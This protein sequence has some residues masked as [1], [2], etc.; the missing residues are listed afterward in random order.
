MG[1]IC[2]TS[3]MPAEAHVGS[4]LGAQGGGVF[5]ADSLAGI[6][7]DTEIPMHKQ[8][9]YDKRQVFWETRIEGRQ[10]AWQTI[11]MAAECGDPTTAKMI[12]SS[13]GLTDYQ[14]DKS[15]RRSVTD[16]CYC[17]DELGNRYDVPLYVLFSPRTL[18]DDPEEQAELAGE[19]PVKQKE[20]EEQQKQGESKLSGGV[21]GST[22]DK[23]EIKVKVRLSSSKDLALS[24]P[25][26][27]NVLQLKTAVQQQEDIAVSRLRV[28]VHGHRLS[29]SE[30]LSRFLRKG[31]IV[32]LICLAYNDLK[33]RLVIVSLVLFQSNVIQ[34]HNCIENGRIKKAKQST[35]DENRAVEEK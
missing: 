10:E 13:A 34:I 27:A 19:S 29:D 32:Q 21:S 30:G 28:F 15:L 3:H 20:L 18:I 33:A 4:Q 11:R 25:I 5:L 26:D 9:L 31:L 14:I 6:E 12:L 23:E 1:N 17:F 22:P 2:G 35:E 16:T 24:L 7:W 8:E